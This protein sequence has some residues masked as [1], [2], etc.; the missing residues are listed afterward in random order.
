MTTWFKGAGQSVLQLLPLNEMAAGEQSPY[1]ALS[2]M[3]ID[4]IYIRMQDVADFVA[5]GGEESLSA[6][7]R[8]ELDRVRQASTVN[9]RSIRRIKLA[10]LTAAFARFFGDEWKRTTPRA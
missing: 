1:S 3:A 5:L 9:Y 4:P 2:A 10:A 8:A 6:E 7:D